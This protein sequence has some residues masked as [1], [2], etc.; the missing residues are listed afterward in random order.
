MDRLRKHTT[1]F[2]ST[3]IL[4]D[5]QQVSDSVAILDHGELLAQGPIE[6]L[7]AGSD[8]PVYSLSLRGDSEVARAR[9]AALPWVAGVD[10]AQHNGTTAWQV[11]VTDEAAAEARLL[12]EV[13]A[14]ERVTV[15][16]F[17]RKR[18]ELEEVFVNTIQGGD[19]GRQ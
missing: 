2:Y 6:A 7:L 13:L 5:V 12:R 19:H 4:D 3:H 17:S 10:V 15:I 1:I 14:D 8:A 18:Y 9:I 16:E 11:R